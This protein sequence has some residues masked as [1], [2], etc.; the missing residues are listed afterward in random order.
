MK[1]EKSLFLV[2]LILFIIS[3]HFPA[4]GSTQTTSFT[5][6]KSWYVSQNNVFPMDAA[7]YMKKGRVF[8]PVRYLALACDVS[9][10]D[11]SY[12]NGIV[13]I[14]KG[15]V[16]LQLKVGSSLLVINNQVI[17]MDVPVEMTKGRTF[18]PARWIAEALGYKVSWDEAT[19]TITVSPR[20]YSLSELIFRIQPAVVHIK[21]QR[22]EGTGFFTSSN[23]EILTNAHVVAG[24][25]FVR[26]TTYDG[27]I[28]NATVAKAIPYVDLA[29]LRVNGSGFPYIPLNKTVPQRGEQIVVLG[30]PLGAKNIISQGIINNASK[31]ISEIDSSKKSYTVIELSIPVYH[32]N[33]GSPVVNMYGEAVGIVFARHGLAHTVG[34]AIPVEYYDGF[35]FRNY[36]DLETDFE[37]FAETYLSEW[38]PQE[39]IANEIFLR[40]QQ[41][42]KEKRLF[43]YL[44]KLEETINR[45][46]S[47]K[48]D[49][50]LYTPRYLEIIKLRN[51]YL[52]LIECHIEIAKRY[53]ELGRLTDPIIPVTPEVTNRVQTVFGELL[54]YIDKSKVLKE[55]FINQVSNLAKSSSSK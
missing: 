5:I 47:L 52:Q 16:N 7:P 6:G 46:E 34:Y 45:L 32:G 17:N 44:T 19:Q 33:S 41:Y 18:L 38:A 42:L 12:S 51:T 14:A 8:V 27:Q 1:R 36:Y 29:V 30:H 21:T 20:T 28:Y 13:Y 24:A 22:G 9:P 39:D 26:V 37:M 23:G 2:I 3:F 50:A 48:E 31:D 25:S 15:S 53:Q 54:D 40:A 4:F 43:S 55:E 49:I 10:T 11:I 35:Q